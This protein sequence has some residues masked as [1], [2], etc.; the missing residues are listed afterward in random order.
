MKSPQT[1]QQINIL[2]PVEK[3]Q[4]IVCCTPFSNHSWQ[5]FAPELKSETLRWHFFYLKPEG[6]L[7]KYVRQ[8]NLAM[9]RT[10][11]Q[12][13]LAVKQHGAT[14]L[15]THEPAVSFWCALFIKQLGVDVE[16]IAYSFNFPKLPKGMK[17]RWMTSAFANISRFVVYSTMEKQLY[18][19]Y[20]GIPL[21]RIDVCLWSVG[22]PESQP[23]TPLET[24]DYICAIG[25][26][27]RDYRSLM[28]A[29]EQLPDIPLVLVARPHNLKNLDI[30][31]NVKVRVNIP[32]PHATNIVEHSRFMVLP[33]VGTEVPCG[34]VT[35][36]ATM[37]LG[38]A[39]IIT[40]SE[41]V[42]D[43]I[44][45]GSNAL[46]CDAFAPDLLAQKIRTLWDNPQL[47]QELGANGRQ[48]ATDN[49]SEVSARQHLANMLVERG[50]LEP[51]RIPCGA[52]KK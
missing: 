22:M 38:K 51:T 17:R 49:C 19:D 13:V 39:F 24:G 11:R 2:Q 42:S 46:T 21:E 36:V 44:S 50:L 33:L 23:K 26:N 31:A 14:I 52:A 28:A 20:F 30:P 6:L 27:A 12:A 35:L 9:I 48:F 37:H 7:E 1:P 8:P 25:G 47:C 29:M 15:F 18:H 43:Y 4:H 40:N 32:K 34:H 5:W 41:G 3:T 10:C 45:D 16:H